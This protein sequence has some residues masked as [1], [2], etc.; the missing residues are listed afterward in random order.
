MERVRVCYVIMPF[1]ERYAPAYTL[2]I[3]PAIDNI[4]LQRGEKWECR[5]SDD[6]KVP[7]SITKEIVTSLHTADLVI[8]DL[9]GNNPN[10]FYELGIAHSAGRPTVIITQHTEALPFDVNTCRIHAYEASAE[11][12]PKLADSLS[13]TI[14]DA[15]A[16]AEQ[17]TN[18]VMDFAPVR[19]TQIILGLDSV[20]QIES[21][22]ANE[23]WV[24][25]PT[26]DT[27]L[28]LFGEIIKRNIMERAVKYRYLVPRTSGITRQWVRFIRELGYDPAYQQTL[29]ARTVDEHLIESEVV[30]YDPYASQEAVLIMSGRERD[31]VFWY[32]V[33]KTRGESIRERYEYLW[34]GVS[35]ALV[36]PQ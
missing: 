23:V 30:I 29:E 4:A 31:F 26:F 1:H 33:G 28:K 2:G 15:L 16:N 5:R 8:A 25:E 32:R 21:S 24:I 20:K 11:G 18:P 36:Q 13:V 7:G 3:R 14:L 9:T 17:M 27:D 34:D 19:Y 6:I 35:E 12:L 10:V 22:V